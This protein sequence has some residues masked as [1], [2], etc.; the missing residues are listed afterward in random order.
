MVVQA[1]RHHKKLVRRYLAERDKPIP[2]VFQEMPAWAAAYRAATAQRALND[3]GSPMAVFAA[4]AYLERQDIIDY[5]VR[6]LPRERGKAVREALARYKRDWRQKMGRMKEGKISPHTA[7]VRAAVKA[8]G[9]AGRASSAD[10]V[11]ALLTSDLGADELEPIRD[12][13]SPILLPDQ[14]PTVDI[15]DGKAFFRFKNRPDRKI[16]LGRFRNMVSEAAR[17]AEID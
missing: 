5:L 9:E 16:S 12:A 7:L 1:Q 2:P 10:A 11:L 15:E 13:L 4:G 17:S 8:L 3:I 14:G 6:T